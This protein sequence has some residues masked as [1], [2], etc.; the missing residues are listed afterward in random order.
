[1]TTITWSPPERKPE[2]AAE[3]EKL[4]AQ[5]VPL[6]QAKIT[7]GEDGWRVRALGPPGSCRGPDFTSRDVSVRI[8]DILREAGHPVTD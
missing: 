6:C 1:M 3:L 8:A 7:I 2:D 5:A 4:I